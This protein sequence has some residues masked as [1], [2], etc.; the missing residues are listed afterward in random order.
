[1]SEQRKPDRTSG[2]AASERISDARA[3]LERTTD[4]LRRLLKVPKSDIQEKNTNRAHGGTH[5]KT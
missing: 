2:E 5:K 3:G 4:L 1:M